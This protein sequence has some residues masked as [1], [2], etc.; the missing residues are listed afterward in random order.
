MEKVGRRDHC[1]TRKTLIAFYFLMKYCERH[2]RGGKAFYLL[3][4]FNFFFR[5]GN[6]FI[7]DLFPNSIPRCLV[8]YPRAVG[9][10]TPSPVV[11]HRPY[12][13]LDLLIFCLIWGNLMSSRVN[14][15]SG[16]SLKK[17]GCLY[18]QY[19]LWPMHTYS[20][21]IGYRFPPPTCLSPYLD[22][23]IHTFLR[24]NST[25][26]ICSC[27]FVSLWRLFVWFVLVLENV[28]IYVTYLFP[29]ICSRGFRTPPFRLDFYV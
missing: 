28:W 2:R 23:R 3:P 5:C 4:E 22:V 14:I 20:I 17:K 24:I 29:Y 11:P 13:L 21:S 8:F 6:I 25:L 7:T 27:T 19:F 18:K 9:A 16:D 1:I 10:I 12:L 15:L 26:D